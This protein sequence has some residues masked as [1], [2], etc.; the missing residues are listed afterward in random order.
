MAEETQQEKSELKNTVTIEE[1]GPCKKKVSVE[2]PAEKI[3][4]ITDEQYTELGRGAIVPGFR[5]GRAPRRL[6]EKRFGKETSEQVK[7]KLLADS[8]KAAIKDNELDVLG[9]PNIDY[10]KIELP[11]DGPMKFDFEVEVRPQFELPG[12]EGI[13]LERPKL[14]ITDEHVDGEIERLCRYNGVWTPR[15]EDESVQTDDQ[16]IAD[17]VLQVEGVEEEEK[18]DDIEAYVRPTGFVGPVPVE[19]LDELLS[20]AKAGDTRQTTIQIPST[21]FK[22]QYRDKKV[23]VK[24]TVKDI[25]YLK[26]AQIDKNLLSNCGVDSE[27]ELKERIR[28]SLQGRLERQIRLGMVEQV[29]KYVLD[30]TDFELPTDAAAAYSTTLLR[31]QYANLLSR[32]LPRE[33]IEEQMEQLKAASEQRAKEQLKIFFIMDKVAEKLEVQVSDEELNGQV[34][35]LAVQQGQRPEKLRQEMER[36]GSLEQFRQQVRDEKCVEKILESAKVTEVEPKKA[37]EK[38]KKTVKSEE[39]PKKAPK[40]AAKPAAKAV[41]KQASSDKSPAKKQKNTTKK[42]TSK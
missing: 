8:S 25:K 28:T 7:L 2:I 39:K 36:S 18:H 42:K 37:A 14:Q 27:D 24:I 10:E 41:E 12:L 30:N 31:R 4:H 1:I 38:P 35:A 20:G 34:A 11:E 3:K 22:E 5:K 13:P 26:P 15:K 6:L 40:K 21:F 29:Y 19:K 17:V 16:I 9:D 32:G 33:Q 23:D